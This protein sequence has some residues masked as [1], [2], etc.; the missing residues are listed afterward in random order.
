MESNSTN[1]IHSFDLPDNLV[2]R[3]EELLELIP[4][5]SWSKEVV[6]AIKSFSRDESI[7]IACSG[8]ADSTLCV[9]LVYAAF[10]NLG[11]RLIITHFNHQLRGE[12]SDH[13]EAFV[14]Q[15]CKKLNLRCVTDKASQD[16]DKSDENSLRNLRMNFWNRLEQNE[17]IT[18]MIQGHHLNDVAET[19]LWRIPRGV[20]VDGLTGP[21]PVSKVG[22]LVFLRP[23]ISLSKDFITN[24]LNQCGIPWREDKSNRQDLYIRNKMR[25]AVLPAWKDSCDRNLLMGI[26][27]TREL[28]EQDSEALDFHANET[29]EKCRLGEAINLD[30]LQKY[31][32]GTQK[33]VL[34]KWLTSNSSNSGRLSFLISNLGN[35]LSTISEGDF[36]NYHFSEDLKIQLK[37]N[38]LFLEK[39]QSAKSI[40]RSMLPLGSAMYFS[41]GNQITA[42]NIQVDQNLFKRFNDGQV[43]QNQEAFL[44][45]K[46]LDGHFYVR[47]RKDG[48]RFF[49]IGAPGNKKV[50]DWMIDRKWTQKQK[51]ETPVL[52]DEH[53]KIQ[54]IPGFPPSESAKVTKDDRWVIRLTYLQLST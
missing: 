21:K 25:H 26:D 53:D 14:Q 31:P 49:P 17:K 34:T 32:T 54:W 20:S 5:H 16:S 37:D 1:M 22:S 39:P 40:P 11:K 18:H 6:S 36:K 3:A 9:L 28:L 13:D 46:K 38:L 23:L 52:V 33:R 43:E 4:L 51:I 19:L 35:A 30:T 42:Q 27:S 24:A 45:S 7:G 12:D 2:E 29:F 10:P 8:G 41:S 47:S 44:S 48:D 50:S 15:L